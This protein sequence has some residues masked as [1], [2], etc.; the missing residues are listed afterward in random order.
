[1]HS[2]STENILGYQVNNDGFESCIAEVAGT[3]EQGRERKWL[4]TLNPHSYAVALKRPHFQAALNAA[5]WLIPDGI[6]I[7][8]ASWFLGGSV[9]HRVSGPDIFYG[10]HNYMQ[11]SGS[12]SV[13]FL[14]S[15]ED[16]LVEIRKRMVRDWP[17]I[18]V[19]GTYS[20]PFKSA[21]SDEDLEQMILRVNAAGPD[22][23]WVGLT[24]PKQEELLHRILPQL[25]VRF[26]AAVGAIFDFY[27]G[28]V[29]R[30]HPLFRRLGLE[31]LPRLL[32]EPRR[33][34]RR[35]FISAPIFLWHVLLAKIH[36]L[37]QVRQ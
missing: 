12:Y 36:R 10:L 6:G 15:S 29:K 30:S 27:A 20:P 3:L 25:N 8:L 33:L 17:N 19:A 23:L 24:A 7:V 2:F 28:R 31:W 9:R 26:A 37:P 35:M 1:M 21:F 5:D 11:Q 4:A 16:T 13:F 32:R 14:G 22:V 18:R 34:W